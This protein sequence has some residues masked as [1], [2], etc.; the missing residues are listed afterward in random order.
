MG[1]LQFTVVSSQSSVQRACSVFTS[2]SIASK[3]GGVRDAT[4]PA[5]QAPGSPRSTSIVRRTHHGS[6]TVIAATRARGSRR[7][8][9]SSAA[10][11]FTIDTSAPKPSTAGLLP[12]DLV[13][14]VRIVPGRHE[15]ELRA[16]AVQR[17]IATSSNAP[18]RL[19]AG[20]VQ[21]RDV[22]VA[23]AP[24]S[25]DLARRTPYPVE[26]VL[27]RRDIEHAGIVVERVLRAVAMVHVVVDD[28]HA[29]RPY[30]RRAYAAATATWLNRRSPSPGPGGVVPRRPHQAERRRHVAPHHRVERG[31]R[32]A[33]DAHRDDRTS[34]A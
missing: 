21:H 26:R 13:G 1:G 22:D 30:V 12:G 6:A 7:P 27:V 31:Q 16:V 19:V 5:G 3:P 20:A 23:P 9:H 8:S 33:D 2:A 14:E 4:A 11:S 24:G 32:A 34:A 25:A 17:G 29:S 18:V 15:H 28:R 10:A